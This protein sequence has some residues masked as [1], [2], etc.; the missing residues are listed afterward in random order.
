MR[1]R[2]APPG[3]MIKDAPFA[4]PVAGL[5][6]VRVGVTTFR[7]IRLP[8][9]PLSCSRQSQVSEPGAAP[10]QIAKVPAASGASGSRDC[11][12]RRTAAAKIRTFL[13]GLPYYSS[14]RAPGGE[15]D[16]RFRSERLRSKRKN[17]A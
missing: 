7:T 13:I 16:P 8:T 14:Q 9:W 15:S 17:G 1:K 11:A 4:L 2:K 3:A 10:G 12:K 5:Y 6:I